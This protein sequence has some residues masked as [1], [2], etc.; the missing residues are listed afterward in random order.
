MFTLVVILALS[1]AGCERY[2]IEIG[3]KTTP[4]GQPAAP[5]PATPTPAATVSGDPLLPSLQALGFNSRQELISFFDIKGVSPSELH[6]CP[7]EVACV[8]I[9]HEKDANDYIAPFVMTNPTATIFDGW[10]CA[11]SAGGQA[12]VPP[13]GP[14]CVEGVT[15]R[16]WR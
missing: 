8:A 7:G 12:K 3:P 13:G 1:V 15:I 2:R 14:W 11:G 5:A 6:G 4:A 16:H 10:R 9:N